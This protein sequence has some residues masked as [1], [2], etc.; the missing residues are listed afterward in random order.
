MHHPKSECQSC[1][2]LGS[3]EIEFPRDQVKRHYD[4]YICPSLHRIEHSHIIIRY[5]KHE[6]E[7]LCTDLQALIGRSHIIELSPQKAMAFQLILSYLNTNW[8]PLFEDVYGSLWF[9]EFSGTDEAMYSRL[10]SCD[11][12]DYEYGDAELPG[13]L[14]RL[15]IS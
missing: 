14:R 8:G 1:I 15:Y 4:V 2:Y 9:E 3:F 6:D 13:T 5:G 11:S 7:Y 10:V 12:R